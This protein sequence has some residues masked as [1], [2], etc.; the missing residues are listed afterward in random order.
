MIPFGILLC[1]NYKDNLTVFSLDHGFW[2]GI[3]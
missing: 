1:V 3:R 2:G